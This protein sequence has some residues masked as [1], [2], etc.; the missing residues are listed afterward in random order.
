MPVIV[1]VTGPTVA[2]PLLLD[3]RENVP[4]LASVELP[5][6]FK[7]DVEAAVNVP[8][9]LKV[10]PPL[11]FSVAPSLTVDIALAPIVTA[12]G[13]VIVPVAFESTFKALLSVS[14][15]PELMVITGDVTTVPKVK[16]P[17]VVLAAIAGAL[18]YARPPTR[19]MVVLMGT[20]PLLLL[21]VL[22]LLASVKLLLLVPTQSKVVVILNAC[23]VTL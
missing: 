22:K 21:S 19:T 18:V 4:V 11:I 1:P 3:C 7:I 12:P 13:P 8:A 20:V 10:A 23:Q 15:L 2:E 9:L 16:P 5:V 6:I 14:V 17:I